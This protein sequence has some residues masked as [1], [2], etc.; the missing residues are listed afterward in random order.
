MKYGLEKELFIFKDDIIQFVPIN[1]GLPFDESGVLI[2]ARG[3]PSSDIIQAVYNL[4]A[5]E[6]RII[7]M[8]YKLEFIASD[9]PI[10]TITRDFKREVRR[11]YTKGLIS[12][13]NMYGYKDNRHSQNEVTAAVHISFTNPRTIINYGKG[14]GLSEQIIVNQFFDFIK[15]IKALD[16]AFKPLISST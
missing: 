1:S 7:K 5:E 15:Y 12:F 3:E 14:K 8:A 9:M 16:K 10:A 11:I 4:K 2:E 6:Y 13:E